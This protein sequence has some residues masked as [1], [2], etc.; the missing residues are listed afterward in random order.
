MDM[1]RVDQVLDEIR[2]TKI[3]FFARRIGKPTMTEIE[4]RSL[5]DEM[6]SRPP[7]TPESLTKSIKDCREA[8]EELRLRLEEYDRHIQDGK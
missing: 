4:F 6:A 8:I 5:M 3:A 1:S 2:M 7:V